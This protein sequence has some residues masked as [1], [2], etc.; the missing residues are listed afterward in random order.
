MGDGKLEGTGQ[1]AADPVQGVEARAAAGVLALHLANHH[2]GIG[3]DVQCPGLELLCTLQGLK[4]GDVFGDVVVLAADPARDADG[5][6]IASLDHNPNAR[7]PRVSQR[8]AIHVGYEV[9]HSSVIRCHQHASEPIFR[10]V[11]YLE[12]LQHRA[13]AVE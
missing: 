13:M 11:V 12:R 8:T 3:I 10:Q 2:L 6:A 4:Q 9:R 7:R 1:L 5:A